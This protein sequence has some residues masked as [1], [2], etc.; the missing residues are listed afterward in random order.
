MDLST[1]SD[2]GT[3]SN[4]NVQS[5][6]IGI[7][8]SGV[9]GLSVLSEI[10]RLAPEYDVRYVADTRFCPYGARPEHEIRDRSLLIGK[11]L[12]AHGA[13]LLVVACNTASAAA[14]EDL[15][16]RLPIPVIGLEPAVKPAVAATKSG[17]VGVFATP[18]TAASVRLARLIERFANEV[19]VR[20]VPAPTWVSLVE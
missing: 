2:N 5:G 4:V 8:D 1:P 18:R 14:L 10:R 15:R 19:E 7:F 11:T 3:M 16:A 13:R 6:C 20:V 17:R 9:G 12:V